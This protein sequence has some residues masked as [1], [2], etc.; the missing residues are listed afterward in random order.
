MQDWVG[1]YTVRFWT[2]VIVVLF[3]LLLAMFG[4]WAFFDPRA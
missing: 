2:G 3:V 1:R 4:Y